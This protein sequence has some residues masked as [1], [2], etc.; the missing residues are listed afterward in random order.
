MHLS[1][2]EER[3]NKALRSVYSGLEWRGLVVRWELHITV[4]GELCHV[5]LIA[6]ADVRLNDRFY[7][8]SQEGILLS[9]WLDLELEVVIQKS[10][11]DEGA[12]ADLIRD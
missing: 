9:F 11:Q 1:R 6:I 10:V 2:I 8:D 4:L 12:S 7:R 5:S 3:V